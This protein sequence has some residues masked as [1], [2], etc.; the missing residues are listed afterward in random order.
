SN[1]MRAI[2]LTQSQKKIELVRIEIPR[3]V[4]PNDVLLKIPCAG[5]CGS[6]IHFIKNTFIIKD[7][8]VLG[9]EFSG[10]VVEIGSDVTNV[11]VGDRV[12]AAASCHCHHCRFCHLGKANLCVKGGVSY[13][14][15]FHR[16]G[17]WADY[18]LVQ[19]SQLFK[20]SDEIDF[21]TS[22]LTEPLSCVVHSFSNYS[23]LADSASI[24]IAG[25]GI[26]GLL[27]A[28]MLHYK[29]FRDITICEPIECRREIAKNLQLSGL[30]VMKPSEVIEKFKGL[31]TSLV[32][33]DLIFDC[34]GSPEAFEDYFPLLRKSA[35]YL[36]FGLFPPGTKSSISPC[37]F[38]NKEVKILSSSGECNKHMDALSL[39]KN[40]AIDGKLD[41]KRLGVKLYPLEDYKTALKDLED[42]VISKAMLT[43]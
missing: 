7:N 36:M 26:I 42:G 21:E 18:C 2:K 4:K 29:G 12:S 5:I 37:D 8:V 41:L 33:Y 40:M 28:S 39:V 38:F 13:Y 25:S 34:T 11:K 16:D 24:L 22:I 27:K 19:S 1:L 6:D 32:G 3:I 23:P 9:H 35:T 10:T 20:L 15:G 31:E 30:Q 14:N 43:L 17:A